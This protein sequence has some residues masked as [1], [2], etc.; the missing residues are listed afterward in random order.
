MTAR[1]SLDSATT[2]NATKGS[3][4]YKYD[5]VYRIHPA[6]DR[7]QLQASAKTAIIFLVP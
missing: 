2:I 4:I 5:D 1:K 3:A 6:K 7:V